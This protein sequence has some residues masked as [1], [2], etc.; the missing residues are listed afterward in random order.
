MR[1]Q[2]SQGVQGSRQLILT[3]GLQVKT[4]S[5]GLSVH[6]ISLSAVLRTN[7]A[8]TGSASI[9][10][11]GSS[12]GLSTYSGSL[13]IS[14]TMCERTTWGADTSVRCQSGHGVGSTRRLVLTQGLRS[15][16]Y[17]K[18]LS[19][20]PGSLSV[21]R[22]GNTAVTG[23]ASVTVHGANMGLTSYSASARS[24]QTACE[25]TTWS[26]DTSVRSQ[27]E[28][29]VGESRR[30]L[31][32]TGTRGG[33][34]TW[35]F[36]T[37]KSV[38]SLM[39]RSNA[40]ATGS[41]SVTVHGAN[42]GLTTT[43]SS[44][45]V[46]RTASEQ[47]TWGADTSLRCQAG[48][49]VGGSRLLLLTSGVWVGSSTHAISAD[50]GR[51]SV[52]RRTNQA[53]TGSSSVTVVGASMGLASFTQMVRSALT[54]CERTT[55]ET[56]TS[57][58]CRGGY[59]VMG[60]RRLLLSSGARVGSASTVY[61]LEV[62]LLTA[63][64]KMN[65]ATTGSASLTVHGANLGHSTYTVGANIGRTACE[66]STW[67]SDTSL[68]CKLS[69]DVRSSRRYLTTVGTRLGSATDGFSME[70][71]AASLSRRV[72]V[73]S[74]SSTSLTLY[75]SD[76]GLTTYTS[77][78]TLSRTAC[79]RTTWQADTSVACMSCSGSRSSLRVSI[80]SGKKDGSL[81]FAFSKDQ[82]V[83]SS[84]L[85]RNI[86]SSGSLSLTLLGSSAGLATFSS[87]VRIRLSACERTTWAA[88]TSLICLGSHGASGTRQVSLTIGFRAGSATL[89]ISADI[90]VLSSLRRTNRASTGSASLTVHGA[91]F[92]LVSFSSALS[93]R[94]TGTDR[95]AW[96]SGTS[97]RCAAGAG[98]AQSA[99][100]T[101]TSGQQ[102][103][104]ATEAWTFDTAST[105]T[106]LA[107]NRASTG[108]S[109][110]T[111]FGLDLAHVSSTIAAAAGNT[112]F[113][114]SEWISDT[115]LRVRASGLVRATRTLALSIVTRLGSRS[116]ALTHDAPALLFGAKVN[117][118]GTG[119]QVVTV[120]G[121]NLGC[122]F[123]STINVRIGATATES[124]MWLSNTATV[125][126]RAVGIATTRGMTLTIGERPG[127]CQTQALSYSTPCASGVE[128]ANVGVTGSGL[129]TVWGAD[130]GLLGGISPSVRILGSACEQTIWSAYS[131]VVCRAPGGEGWTGTTTVSAGRR[132]GT[133]TAVVTYDVSAGSSARRANVAATGASAVEVLAGRAFGATLS[134]AAGRVGRSAC[135]TT[136]WV[137]DTSMTLLTSSGIRGSKTVALTAGRRVGSATAA[138]S[139]GPPA[140]D[141]WY[142]SGGIFP[143]VLLGGAGYL[144]GDLDTVPAPSGP[145]GTAF[146]G[147]FTIVDGV[148]NSIAV[149][150]AGSLY[151]EA[152]TLVPVYQGTTT[153]QDGTV[154]DVT[155]VNRGA[156]YLAGT[157]LV[158][159]GGVA[160]GF[161]ANFSVDADGRVLAVAIVSHGRACRPPGI[162]PL[163]L[164]YDSGSI[165]DGTVSGID[166]I[167][168]GVN[169]IAGDVVLVSVGG[170]GFLA[171]FSVNATG[172]VSVVT[173]Q[174]VGAG[175]SGQACSTRLVYA[176]GS[177]EIS[178]SITSIGVVAGGGGYPS[179]G[180]AVVAAGGGGAG[181]VG[182]F[183]ADPVTGT[184]TA[185]RVL[186]PGSNYTSDPLLLPAYR[187]S[188]IPMDYTVPSVLVVAGGSNYLAGSLV[189]LAGAGAGCGFS[190]QL[191]VVSGAVVAVIVTT[192]G[193]GVPVGVGAG[194]LLV[195][196]SP[197]VWCNGSLSARCLQTGSVTAV[198]VSGAGNR[199]YAAGPALVVCSL[200]CTGA[201]LIASCVDVAIYPSGLG[202]G[203]IDS[204]EV[205]SFIFLSFSS[206]P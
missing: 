28:Q 15:G 176:D 74:T 54:A 57:T 36:S 40:A 53:A 21:T 76:L 11:Q 47:T 191:E 2:T 115:T 78:F 22:R 198:A 111:L 69:Q 166:V 108:S 134:S 107:S 87:A 150:V 192:P 143:Q 19:L 199:H 100:I 29:G 195:Y 116:A 25:Q 12:M 16:S 117:L 79:E 162:V 138:L 35:S 148:I 4:A 164:A 104:T 51:F 127:G 97:I 89:P 102:V 106:A 39:R 58:R 167:D 64:R 132:S 10:V 183:D 34:A 77:A 135:E 7:R 24:G 90:G 197:E 5:R 26:S 187:N 33:S 73:V 175:Y 61:S 20:S 98:W 189:E 30:V 63:L 205:R 105:S 156:N 190:G 113:E 96:E 14:V 91:N 146:A 49:G 141:Q 18:G 203:I 62:G 38:A 82:Y 56:D 152:P 85:R 60:S 170:A 44:V 84:A 83:L 177:G 178:N 92:G 155:V 118:A 52:A 81:T 201:G 182:E 206:C 41:L 193:Q 144:A 80:T 8:A 139:F 160:P 186:S 67:E 131:S 42:V 114:A 1:C 94:S 157:V 140:V 200:P 163:Q 112:A 181:F 9:T 147:A 123:T 6:I 149:D 13:R 169:Y 171:K 46:G 151:S 45:R 71:F 37:D 70:L 133:R 165:M 185:V 174:T 109:S 3:A 158:A 161:A 27:S 172:G 126:K 125:G 173:V 154:T 32:T 184:I 136:R 142:H 88:D 95:T 188:G 59:A 99:Q 75:G 130:F 145:I 50:L 31:V 124:T 196:Y 48:H 153:P 55:W 168:G 86:V 17:T 68:R 23:G 110:V 159:P 121:S 129:L 66:R 119:P 194:D 122:V 128:V 179:T 137:S 93:L 101:F 65:R 103:G 204:I 43:S 120:T 202:D 180:G 72:N